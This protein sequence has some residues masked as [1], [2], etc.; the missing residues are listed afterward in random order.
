[1]ALG[2]SL[3][4]EGGLD[5]LELFQVQAGEAALVGVPDFAGLAEGGAENADGVKAAGLDFGWKER[6]GFMMATQY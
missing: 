3:S 5:A 6:R 2:E 1:M 4:G